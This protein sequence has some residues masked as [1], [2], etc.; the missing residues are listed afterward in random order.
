MSLYSGRNPEI[1]ERSRDQ[2]E[3]YIASAKVKKKRDLAMIM[4]RDLLIEF[5]RT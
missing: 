1:P 4:I 5:N 3:V 2:V